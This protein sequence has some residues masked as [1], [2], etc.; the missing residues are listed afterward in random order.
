MA[1]ITDATT[2]WSAPVTLSADELWQARK[3][4]VYLTTTG[5]PDTNDGLMLREGTA[6]HLSAGLTVR[7][8]TEGAGPALI[9][10]EAV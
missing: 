10:R 3:E 7:Y 2:T 5:A 4:G 1:L 8:R 9:A 6:V